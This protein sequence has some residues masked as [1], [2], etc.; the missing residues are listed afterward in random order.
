MVSKKPALKDTTGK[1]MSFLRRTSV[2]TWVLGLAVFLGF[3]VILLF[4]VL[5]GGVDL[6]VGQVSPVEVMAPNTTVHRAET[7]RLQDEAARAAVRQASEDPANYQVNQASIIYAEENLHEVFAVLESAMQVDVDTTDIEPPPAQLIEAAVAEISQRW[8]VQLTAPVVTALGRK[9]SD[10]IAQIRLWIESLI[11]SILREGIATGTVDEA[12]ADLRRSVEG[13]GYS[14]EIRELALALGRA[15]LAPNMILDPEKVEQARQAAVRAV[16][17]VTIIQGEVILRRGDVVRPEHIQTLD[18]LGLRREGV[19]Y[20]AAVGLVLFTLLLLALPAVYLLQYQRVM[21][22]QHHLLGLLG[23]VMVVVVL[24]V[25][26]LDLIQWQAT[27]FLAPVALAGM[28]VTL[29]LDSRLGL[30][31]VM[32]LSITA[33]VI[34]GYSFVIGFVVLAGGVASVY[35]L[36]HISQRGDLMRAGFIVGAIQFLAMLALALMRSDWT[37]ASQSYLAWVNGVMSSI[38]AIG[39]LPYLE[40]LFGIT[41][42]IK[43]LELSNPNQKLLRRLLMETPGTY[44]HSILVGNLAEAAADAIGADGLLA[45]V[46]ATYH[47]I[48]KLKRPF[49]FGENQIGSDNPHDKMAPS[50][51]TLIITSHVK[52]GLELAREY[53]LPDVVTQFIAQHHGTDLVKY[54][55]HRAREQG[56]DAVDEADFRYPGP[57]PQNKELAIVSLADAVE[58]AVR[59]LSKPTPGKIEGLVRK[60]VKDRL[61]DGQLDECDLTFRELDR[62][63]QAFT[64]VLVGIFH[65]RVEYPEGITKED[66]EGK[67]R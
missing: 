32:V 45:R 54:F 61:N 28:L 39:F 65:A 63:A 62:I 51:S 34:G 42:A 5:P 23:L 19:D 43:L 37:L 33:G 48:G 20:L 10:D 57:K 21:L 17:P 59:S 50:L 14:L 56:H 47:D 67:R 15:F 22:R 49:F 46:G 41:S 53:K 8:N 1:A 58:A 25:K 40:S 30:V 3:F 6:V 60:I 4:G 64:T 55:F 52:D 24:L 13:S 29:L 18:E 66:I 16:E 11:L 7:Q 35:T 27:L 2:R 12:L 36:S 9:Q 26:I 38:V 44:H 31:T